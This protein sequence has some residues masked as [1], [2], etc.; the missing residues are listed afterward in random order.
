MKIELTD[1]EASM[2]IY[3]L[4]EMGNRRAEQAIEFQQPELHAES[5]AHYRLADKISAERTP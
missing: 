5:A 2:A 1:D 3:A 4:K